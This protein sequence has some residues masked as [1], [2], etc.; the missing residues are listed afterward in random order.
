MKKQAISALL[1]C[2]L[3]TAVSCGDSA[4]AGTD[5]PD[6]KTPTGTESA[7][8]TADTITLLSDTLPDGDF[9]GTLFRIFGETQAM[10]GDY[11]TVEN[12]TGDVIEDNVFRRNNMVEDK[13]NVDLDFYLVDQWAGK[14]MITTYIQSGDDSIAL[15]TNTYLNLGALLVQN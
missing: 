13:Y 5:T 14:D 7:A 6:T 9:N 3:L 1:A 12:E 4:Q 10:H 15:F 2:L 11:F 8:D